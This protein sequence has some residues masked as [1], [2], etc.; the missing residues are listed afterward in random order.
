MK[1]YRIT[2]MIWLVLCLAGAVAFTPHLGALVMDHRDGLRTDPHGAGFWLL[3]FFAE[4]F[5]LAGIVAG[6][7]LMLRR[8]WGAIWMWGTAAV[9]LCYS[10]IFLCISR[11][12]EF[13][14]AWFLESCFGIALA[15]YSLFVVWKFKPCETAK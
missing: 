1:S 10:L 12:V 4:A 2:G 6:L 13:H 14:I 3:Q 15:A 8:R 5:L 9:L 11:Y 7:G